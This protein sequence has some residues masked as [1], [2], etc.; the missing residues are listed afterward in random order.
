MTRN[1][2]NERALEAL[3]DSD[4]ALAKNAV[5]VFFHQWP[6][7]MRIEHS[8]DR[9]RIIQIALAVFCERFPHRGVLVPI[10]DGLFCRVPP[11]TPWQEMP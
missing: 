6:G 8:E 4:K 3:C 7:H 5:Y 1:T 11:G 10:G 2:P 9:H